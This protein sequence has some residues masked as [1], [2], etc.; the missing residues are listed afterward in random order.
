[1]AGWPTS[2]TVGAMSPCDITTSGLKA[3]GVV[4][5]ADARWAKDELARQLALGGVG[6][7]AVSEPSHSRPGV[8]RW[9]REV[10][11]TQLSSIVVL[12]YPL[13]AVPA[14]TFTPDEWERCFGLPVPSLM[15]EF[16]WKHLPLVKGVYG[17]E[18]PRESLTKG[19]SLT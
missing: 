1:M 11:S 9:G 15:L 12:D 14:T 13:G 19:A 2:D 6:V 17:V 3:T 5:V 10:W 16:D 18:L 4:A 7:L 8:N